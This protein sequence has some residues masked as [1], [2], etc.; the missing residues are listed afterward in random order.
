MTAW[1]S[2][3]PGSSHHNPHGP[4]S[5]PAKLLIL[6]SSQQPWR[7]WAAAH[8]SRVQGWSKRHPEDS[9]TRAWPS[10]VDRQANQA[11]L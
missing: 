11:R 1:L 7:M 3:A 9:F 8:F 5:R 10:E 2:Q 6:S 4:P